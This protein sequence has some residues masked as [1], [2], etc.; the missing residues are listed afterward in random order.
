MGRLHM[1]EELEQAAKPDGDTL[2]MREIAQANPLVVVCNYVD[3]MFPEASAAHAFV[4][5]LQMATRHPGWARAVADDFDRGVT[6]AKREATRRNIDKL[7]QI[8]PLV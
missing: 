7:A 1:Q 6:D 5:G 4:M 2:M 8:I 3:T